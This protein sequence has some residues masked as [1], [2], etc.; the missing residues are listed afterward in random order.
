M[1]TFAKLVSLVAALGAVGCVQAGIE[2]DWEVTLDGQAATCAEVMGA[3][4]RVT[5][6]NTQTS[7]IFID[8][9]ACGA[10]TGVTQALPA[11]T[12]EVQVDLMDL[13]NTAIS[14]VAMGGVA[15]EDAKVTLLPLV[16]FALTTP[17]PPQGGQL[18]ATWD[19]QD[20][21]GGPLTCADVGGDMVE[22][23]STDAQMVPTID[24]FLCDAL[25]GTTADLPAGT[26]EVVLTLLDASMNPLSTSQP[27]TADV[28]DGQVFELGN[29]TF[30][31]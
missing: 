13:T 6:T 30:V 26:Y 15:V 20:P 25:D 10:L 1:R 2:L 16:T 28:V 24:L 9:F 12:Y 27:V 14:G 23:V 29:F 18:H 17:P 11:G 5:S 8:R 31:P 3:D 7:Q 21:A 4:V 22:V 19:I